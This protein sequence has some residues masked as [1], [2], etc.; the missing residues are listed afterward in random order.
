MQVRNEPPEMDMGCWSVVSQRVQGAAG[1]A[2]GVKEGEEEQEEAGGG[3]GGA[4]ERLNGEP[5][6]K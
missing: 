5:K 3:G 6:S 4:G 2:G 1:R